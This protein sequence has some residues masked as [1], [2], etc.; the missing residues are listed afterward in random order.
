MYKYQS[1]YY[2]E[3]FLPFTVD[4]CVFMKNSGNAGLDKLSRIFVLSAA[5]PVKDIIYA[6]GNV[7]PK[8]CPIEPVSEYKT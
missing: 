4:M 5:K 6:E 3:Q 8:N 7:V 1:N 2:Q